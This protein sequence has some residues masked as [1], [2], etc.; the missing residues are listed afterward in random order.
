ML[1]TPSGEMPPLATS[2]IVACP[3]TSQEP[4]QG[5]TLIARGLDST[6]GHP[7]EDKLILVTGTPLHEH[8][9]GADAELGDATEYSVDIPSESGQGNWTDSG[10]EQGSTSPAKAESAAIAGSVTP[11]SECQRQLDETKADGATVAAAVST[12]AKCHI[13]K[14]GIHPDKVQDGCDPT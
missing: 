4:Q 3:T 6:R 10:S 5:T 8:M 14:N 7:P 11:D 1:P 13:C 9:E 12:R 2:S